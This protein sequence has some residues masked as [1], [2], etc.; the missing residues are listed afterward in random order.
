M[1]LN[2]IAQALSQSQSKITLPLYAYDTDSCS[3]A[4]VDL[5]S[6]L[7][8]TF[9]DFET[10]LYL[11]VFANPCL[12]WLDSLT[13]GSER[14][15]LLVNSIPELL[16]VQTYR[17]RHMPRVAFAGG[18][19]PK[20]AVAKACEVADHFYA[21]SVENLRYAV[22]LKNRRARVGLRVDLSGIGDSRGIRPDRLANLVNDE[23]D[24]A[25]K[26]ESLHAYQEHTELDFGSCL[27][28]GRMLIRLAQYM[29]SLREINFSGGWPFDYS[30]IDSPL[31]STRSEFTAS[32]RT[33][34]SECNSALGHSKIRELIWEPGKFLLA[35]HGYYFCR[36]IEVDET[37]AGLYDV[38]FESSFT[39]LPALKLKGRKHG[40]NLLDSGLCVKYG[41][42]VFCRLRGMSGLSTDFLM[43]GKVQMPKP[44]PGDIVAIHDVGV[45]GWAGSYN[46]L[47][48]QRPAEYA[49]SNSKLRLLRRQQDVRHLLEGLEGQCHRETR[50]VSPLV[51]RAN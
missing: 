30:E 21:A 18:V 48:M 34:N 32:L 26:I 39:H 43:P 14:V 36:I 50:A 17:W 5:L 40:L 41:E 31:P 2:R 33:L 20:E 12:P 37:T 16:S 27:I 19:L 8:D 49:L 42:S 51:I 38:H 13:G 7:G 9:A 28:H 10:R 44:S 25:Q 1:G 6:L 24:L 15:G 47:G 23:P 35:A 46:F 29:T 22:S 4:V 3:A 45:Y 11:P